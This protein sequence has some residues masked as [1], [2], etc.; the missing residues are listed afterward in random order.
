MNGKLHALTTLPQG[1][2]SLVPLE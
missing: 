1:K 2:E